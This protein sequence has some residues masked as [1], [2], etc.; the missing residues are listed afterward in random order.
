MDWLVEN[1]S[2]HRSSFGKL[3]RLQGRWPSSADRICR[4]A[5]PPP[6]WA[7]EESLAQHQM[8]KLLGLGAD[9]VSLYGLETDH[10]YARGLVAL[11][12]PLSRGPLSLS[13]DHL[14]MS[15]VWM[16]SR[17]YHLLYRYRPLRLHSP[18]LLCRHHRCHH[19]LPSAA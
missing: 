7:G 4:L 15:S 3:R 10:R 5:C 9:L 18:D 1:G 11:F 13:A 14:A 6:C 17:R 19:I 8:C 2:A 16:G 12:R